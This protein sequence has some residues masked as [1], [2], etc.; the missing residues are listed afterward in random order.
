MKFN[1][2]YGLR[3][4]AVFATF[5]AFGMVW[6][7]S[8]SEAQAKKFLVFQITALSGSSYGRGKTSSASKL[9]FSPLWVLQ[10]DRVATRGEDGYN[11]VSTFTG[12]PG[13]EQ[14]LAVNDRAKTIFYVLNGGNGPNLHNRLIYGRSN[15]GKGWRFSVLYQQVDGMNDDGTHDNG[16]GYSITPCVQ[17][18]YK[19]QSIGLTGFYPLNLNLRL[20]RL[21]GG[22]DANDRVL[23]EWFF[24]GKLLPE[25]TRQ[26]NQQN[27]PDNGAAQEWILNSYYL[28]Q[29]GYT[30]ASDVA[31]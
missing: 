31:D 28:G 23:K 7:G 27:L 17:W 21:D 18:P 6:L 25:L 10:L 24:Q 15:T 9:A 19:G 30:R 11:E 29:K 20:C 16:V 1:R 5:V 14:Y 13:S 12:D 2:A 4:G 8:L 22:A 26:L 3:S